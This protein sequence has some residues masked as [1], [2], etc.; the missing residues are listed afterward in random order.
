MIEPI[1]ESQASRIYQVVQPVSRTKEDMVEALKKRGI[2][3]GIYPVENG[4]DGSRLEQYRNRIE[5][6]GL[7][8]LIKVSDE[9]P[10]N[11]IDVKVF[12][13]LNNINSLLRIRGYAHPGSP[14][15]EIDIDSDMKDCEIVIREELRRTLR[16]EVHHMIRNATAGPGLTLFE[17][18][19]EEGL[20]CWYE[21]QGSDEMPPI[22]ATA[23]TL[24]QRDAM[25]EK[26][27]EEFAIT[28]EKRLYEWYFGGEDIPKWSLYTLGY[29]FVGAYLQA[30]PDQ[31]ASDLYNVPAA[32]FKI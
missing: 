6:V 23:L 10:I 5:H 13:K 11:N 14:T 22:Y 28:E 20:A 25:L 12:D 15:L 29:H 30:H 21:I 4:R 18:M 9:M 17:R 8:A 27:K 24:E 32:E 16:H 19:I 26:A 31:K 1:N 2:T 3:F 7:S